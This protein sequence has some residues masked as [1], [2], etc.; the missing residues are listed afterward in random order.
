MIIIEYFGEYMM[1]TQIKMIMIKMI[2]VE[3]MMNTIESFGEYMMSAQIKMIMIKMIHVEYMMNTI[4]Y[5]GE[6]MM[7]A[8]GNGNPIMIVLMALG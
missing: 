3:Y 5:F 2:H 7:S 8:L 1:S 6:Y 4:E